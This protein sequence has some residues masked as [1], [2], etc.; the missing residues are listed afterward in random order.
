[1]DGA[2]ITI[3]CSDGAPLHGHLWQA[4]DAEHGTVIVNAAT[5]VPARYYHRYAR[6]LAE[7]GFAALT[8]D[9]RGI[10]LSRPARLRGFGGDWPTW[11]AL[12]F[13]AVVAFAK[14]RAPDGTLAVVGH[15]IGGVLIG[16]APSAPRID[17]ILTIGAQYAYW[18]DYAA[19]H[20]LRL[21]LRW[22][23]IMP[24]LT[25]LFGYFP[26]R[27]LGWL[28][29]L[30]AGVAREW[31]SRRDAMEASYPAADRTAILARFAAV[32]APIL[33]VSMSDDE[34][35]TEPAMTRTLSY[36]TGC[37][38]RMV[39]LAPAALGQSTVGHFALFHSRYR[40]SFW[41]AT[42]AWLRDGR[43]PWPTVEGFCRE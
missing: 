24:I 28:E 31:S 17:R 2:P 10:G 42:L 39:R 29:D 19:A 22:H 4:A 18:R 38:R 23:V 13:E 16:F 20:R 35:A 12:D 32:R 5:G 9:Y 26:G 43:D 30:P 1:M 3:L 36:F 33:A 40:D 37:E 15:S 34:Y 14:K 11:G 7:N 21:V 8:Y 41:P 27:R 6:Y 25:A